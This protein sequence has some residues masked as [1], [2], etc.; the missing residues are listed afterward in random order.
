MLVLAQRRKIRCDAEFQTGA[1][2]YADEHIY[3][4]PVTAGCPLTHISVKFNI[5]Q[6]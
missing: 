3:A 1:C 4:G 2:H 6:C 5:D